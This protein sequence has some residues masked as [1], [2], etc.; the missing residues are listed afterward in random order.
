ML[1][2]CSGKLFK[3]GIGMR[4]NLRGVIYTNLRFTRDQKIETAA[5]SLLSISNFPETNAVIYEIEE[6]MEDFGDGPGVLVSHGISSYIL[7]FSSILSFTLNCTASPSYHLTDR[8]L[9]D[10]LGVTTHSTPRDVVKQVFDKNIYCQPQDEDFLVKFN[11]QLIGL[12]RKT[13]LGVMSSIRTYVTGMQRI[14]DDFELAYTLLVASIESLA[15]NFDGHQSTWS[16]YDSK[17]KKPI[18][19]ALNGVDEIIADRVRDA[20]LLNEHTALSKRFIEFSIK[21]INS[22]YYREETKNTIHPIS[23]FDLPTALKNA[24][25]ARSKYIHNLHKLPKPLDRPTR[26]T[27]TCRIANKTWLTLQGL[28]RLAR[29]VLIEFVMRQNII[30]KEQY[31]YHLERSNIMQVE[32]APEYWIWQLDFSDG[33]G[34]QKLKGFLSQLASCM[35]HVPNSTVTELTEV[36]DEVERKIDSFKKEDKRAYIA[37]YIAYY[38]FFS[39]PNKK[40]KHL[41]FIKYYEKQ[42]LIPCTEGLIITHLLSLTPSWDLQSHYD[43]I[44]RYFKERDHKGKIRFPKIFEAGMILQLAERYR[45]NNNETKVIELIGMAVESYPE[46]AVLRQFEEDYKLESGTICWGQILSPLKDP[47]TNKTE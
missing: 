10:Q 38:H 17:K 12:D 13:Y 43:C 25:Q 35:E 40:E 4:N 29:H 31:D 21:H 24:Y 20:I 26:Y 1:Q 30:E 23:R 19:K 5:G 15:Q 32:L 44:T 47:E 16:D 11:K 42:I 45:L 3:N 34:S 33:S 14:A 36:L 46:H 18:D 27:E 41:K 28:S 22:A 2:I 6:L 9:G 8:L 39:D 7:D 37:L